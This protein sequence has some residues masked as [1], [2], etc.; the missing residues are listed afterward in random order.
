MT[1][2]PADLSFSS[3]PDDFDSDKEVMSEEEM[4]DSLLYCMNGNQPDLD[5]SAEFREEIAKLRKRHAEMSDKQI[6]K[7][8]VLQSTSSLD[9][10]SL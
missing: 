4:S 10:T 8:L 7:K 2:S 1:E 3:Q 6:I 9:E 5:E